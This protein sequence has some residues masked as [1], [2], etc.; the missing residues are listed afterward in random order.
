MKRSNLSTP[1][2]GSSA[3][4]ARADDSHATYT[5]SAVI[6]R[7]GSIT[8]WS[9]GA[10]RLLGYDDAEIVG[11]SSAVLLAEGVTET[12]RPSLTE[13][14]RWSGR[15]ALQHRDGRR[16]DVPLLAHRRKGDAGNTE[17]LVVSPVRDSPGQ[18][19]NGSSLDG[20]FDQSPWP[21]AICDTDRRLLRANQ[22][23]ERAFALSEDEMRGLWVLEIVLDPL[24]DE[25]D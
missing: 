20:I 2:D 8:K 24:L 10:S 25:S 6:D 7:R 21:M 15:V 4:G 14:T 17:W 11:Q 12:V 22:A 9:R 5:A 16:L 19:E 1:R 13:L 23:M 3:P 18:S